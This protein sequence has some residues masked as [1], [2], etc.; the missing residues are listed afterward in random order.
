MRNF[1]SETKM[2]YSEAYFMFYINFDRIYGHHIH[3]LFVT[4]GEIWLISYLTLF[5]NI[6]NFNNRFMGSLT[7]LLTIT[8]LLG[9]IKKS[10]PKTSEFK[11]IILWFVWHI[12][13]MVIVVLYHVILDVLMHKEI[14]QDGNKKKVGDMTTTKK[15]IKSMYKTADEE[16]IN[17]VKYTK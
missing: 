7:A 17:F 16:N 2:T 14:I 8:F 13:N 6:K 1:S 9:N 3:P 5:I 12:T 11:Y 15:E 4:T 10:L